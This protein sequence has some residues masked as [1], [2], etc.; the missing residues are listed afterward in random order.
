MSLIFQLDQ[1]KKE[2]KGGIAFWIKLSSY[3]ILYFFFGKYNVLY[4]SALNGTQC[5]YMIN[6]GHVFKHRT[7][8][9]LFLFISKNNHDWAR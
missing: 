7:K 6:C 2:K 5:K 9:N 1:T 3:T 8:P 4:F